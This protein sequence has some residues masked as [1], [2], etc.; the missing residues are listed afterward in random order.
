MQA[1]SLMNRLLGT[2]PWLVLAGV[3]GTFAGTAW[4]ADQPALQAIDVQPLPG[5]QLQITLRLSGPAPQPLSFTIDNPAR[6]SFDLPNTTLALASRR[7]DVHASGLDTILAAET[8]DRTRLVL[9][10]DKLVPYDTRVEGNNIIVMLGGSAARASAGATPSGAVAAGGGGGVRELRAIDFRRSTD[11]AG[12]VIVRLSDPHMHVNLHQIG[13]QVV[14]DFSDASVPANLMRR[15]DASDFGTPIRGFDVTR[16]GNG[17]RISITASGDYEQLAYQSDDQ[18]VVEIAPRRKAAN[19]QEER[20]VYTGERL[21]LNFQDIETRAV[22]Q[23]LADASGQNIVVSDSV[24]GNVTLRL[25]N[26]PWD[27]ALD[28]VL[29]TKGL[30][31]RRQDNVIIVAP[32]AELASREKAELAARKDVQELAPLRSE[33]LQVNYAKAQDM[34]ALIKTQTNSLLSTRGSVAV[35]DRTN[36]LLLQDTADRL[37]DVRR[38]VATLDIPVRQVL[39]E[40]RIVIVNNDFERSLGARFG[41]T[42]YQ[43]YGSTGLV[44]TTGTAAGTDLA[45]GSALTNVASTGSIYPVSVPTGSSATNR[46]NVNLPVTSA[47][48][49]IALGILGNNFI[50]DLELSAAQAETQANIISSPRVITA[51]Q[52]EAIIEQGVE[53]PYQQSASSGATTI[54]FKKAVLSLK[55]KP[56]ITPD[57]RIILDLDVKDDAVGTVVVTSGGVNV[58]SIDTRE[59]TTQVLVNDGQTVVLG[60]IL[61]TTQREDDTKVPYLG[62]LPVLG[63]LFKN[64]IHKDDK[65]ELMIFITPKIVREGVNVYN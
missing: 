37:A 23:L 43:K 42:N 50:V 47:A 4:A 1:S 57:N 29:R 24:S 58:P 11:G 34:A 5:Q 56:Q 44:T 18:Y 25:Q 6:I 9:N 33:Y 35:D 31:K 49:T 64:T 19:A 54:Q 60:G 7:I 8:K 48:G 21:T 14:V 61:S 40:A 36:T 12:R 2:A 32:Q 10:L 22:L 30:D 3:L 63:H 15:Y 62:D 17:S 26:V 27:Q 45:I 41:L 20:P 53:I 13:D 16:V 65:D 51:N 55:V 28:I 52:K 46:Y 59:I 38:L 39:I